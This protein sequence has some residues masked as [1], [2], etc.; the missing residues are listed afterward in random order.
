MLLIKKK[1]FIFIE[2][3][4]NIEVNFNLKKL[5]EKTSRKKESLPNAMISQ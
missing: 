2:K 3:Y 1:R 5:F 4:I